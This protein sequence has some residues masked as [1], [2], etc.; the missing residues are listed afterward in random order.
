MIRTILAYLL[1]AYIVFS[2]ASNMTELD[3][4]I[5]EQLCT[6]DAECFAVFGN[7]SAY[8]LDTIEGNQP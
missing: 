8:Y 6:T 4:Y 1:W 7:D 3:A 5:D 2:T